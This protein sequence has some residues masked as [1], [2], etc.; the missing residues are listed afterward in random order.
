[1]SKSGVY[2]STFLF[3][4]MIVLILLSVS[5]AYAANLPTNFSETLFASTLSS[6]TAME[7]APDGRLFVT[8]Q[9]GALR[10]IENGTLL[11]NA[12]VTLSVN[13]SGERGLLG[14]T[15]DPNFATNHFVYVYYTVPT[16]PIHNR[17]S[18]F[19]ANGNVAVSGSEVPILD[20]D[21]LSSATNHNGGAIHFGPDGKLYIG[22]GEN[23]NGANAQTLSNRLGKML[24]INKDGTI[25][26]DNPFFGT[27]TGLNRSIWALGLRNPFTFGFQPGTGRMFID[28]VGQSTWE[29]I[30]DGIA[31]SNYGWPTT[32]GETT[33]PSFVSPLFVYP[34]GAGNQSGCAIVGGTFYNPPVNQFPAS[35]V[36]DYFFGDLCNAWIQHYDPV[37]DTAAA[38]ANS[39]TS[40]LVDMKVGS[41]GRLYYLARGGGS[42]TGVVYRVQYNEP[43]G[44]TLGLYNTSSG[45]MSLIDTVQDNPTAPHY[46][47]FTPNAPV[48]GSSWVM[49]DWDGDGQKTPGV[50]KN[51]AFFYTNSI[52]SSVSWTGVWLGWLQVSPVAG[53]FDSTVNHDCFGVVELDF[54]PS[55]FG[56]PL[57]YTCNLSAGSHPI[58]GQWLG[59]VLPSTGTYQFAAG[60]WNNDGL[61]SVAARRGVYIS[62][63]N[64]P[65]ANGVASFPLAQYIGAPHAGTGALV[66]GDWDNDGV[67]S[68]GLYYSSDG[69]F[70]RRNDLD[71]NSGVYLL[72]HVGLPIGAAVPAS[73]RLTVSLTSGISLPGENVNPAPTATPTEIPME[74]PILTQ[75]QVELDAPQVVRSGE[76]TAL[77]EPEGA[78]GGSYLI[79]S[80]PEAALTLRFIGTSARV[81][82][83]T[84]PSFGQF[85]LLVD[86]VAQQMVTSQ[87]DDYG[88]GGQAMVS[89]LS[90]GAHEL[91]IVPMN[92]V[93]A[94]DAFI[95]TQVLDP[96]VQPTLEPTSTETETP[97][98]LPT[99]VPTDQPTAEPTE[100]PSAEPT[101]PPTPTATLEPLALPVAAS[102]DD[103]APDWRIGSGWVLAT[104]FAYGDQGLG[105]GVPA[106]N[107]TDMLRWDRQLDLRTVVPGQ[108]VQLSY[109][110]LL[111]STQ[112]TA[113][114][115]VSGDGV[116]W[117]TVGA[118]ASWAKWATETIDLSAYAGQ[119]L[120]VQFVWTGVAPTGEG[121]S[122]DTWQIDAVTVVTVVPTS[123]PTPTDTATEIVAPTTPPT[124]PVFMPT[125]EATQPDSPTAT[126]TPDSAPVQFS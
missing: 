103:G 109:Q 86:G 24:R 39:T 23:A 54:T 93:A 123:V 19:T 16:T 64:V 75:T 29:E 55:G 100:L 45:A 63:G 115:Q 77:T 31:G 14:V 3:V 99:V 97:V 79:N 60:D 106:A 22:V 88:V 78:S 98:L 10:V 12:F 121:Q 59:V 68:F 37:T 52:G 111:T 120:Q 125:G 122:A 25:P 116:N 62:W 96:L 21:N 112:S 8:Q 41:D 43:S 32:E 15:F 101:E 51:G 61:D 76:W 57:H 4:L 20:L 30:D 82:Y 36:G 65:P 91:Q 87:A 92:G 126:D 107:Q 117:V 90:D 7:F 1:M 113:E 74:L 67:D 28:D 85:T 81:V 114:V 66:A 89:G 27:A 73:W 119:L 26:S 49:G 33:N 104:Q 118:A 84:G 108:A 11:S 38:F 5:P 48:V 6:P 70:Y 58:S 83:V 80:S 110:S 94:I 102:M 34:H 18:R 50:Y 13:S 2:R 95:V 69:T 72:Q 56:F 47:T 53:R 42:N 46:N 44:D 40:N 35:Y 124:E 105:W 17:V 9:G 71:W